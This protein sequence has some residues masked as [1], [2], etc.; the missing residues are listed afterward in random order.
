[1]FQRPRDGT[2][3]PTEGDGPAR[4]VRCPQQA[5]PKW[6]ARREWDVMG[7][8]LTEAFR[9]IDQRFPGLK[10]PATEEPVFVLAA[11]WRS[12]STLLQPIL[13]KNCLVWGEPYGSSAIIERLSQPLLRFDAYWPDP[14]S[15]LSH[16]DW[17]GTWSEKWTAN[18]SPELE[19]LLEAHLAFFR[20]LFEYP[21]RQQGFKRWGLKEGRYKVEHALYLRLVFPRARV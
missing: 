13:L 18:L 8:T 6:S 10:S 5:P 14:Q 9:L 3:R 7:R 17:K 12:G 19:H 2:G 16:P 11:G 15:F 1:T 4:I 21:A 20:R